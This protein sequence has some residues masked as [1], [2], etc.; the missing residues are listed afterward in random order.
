[1]FEHVL[2]TYLEDFF[3]RLQNVFETNINV[4]LGYLSLTNLNLYVT[5]IYLTN[6][7]LTNLRRMEFKQHFYFKTALLFL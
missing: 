2:K 1:M 5:N 6:P 7:Y 3:R 4:Y